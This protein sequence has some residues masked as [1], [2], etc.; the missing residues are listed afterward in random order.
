[1]KIEVAFV[2]FPL[3]RRVRGAVAER[4]KECVQ[5]F[6]HYE[7]MVRA[8][9]VLEGQE[10]TA[11]LHVMAGRIDFTV[12]ASSNEVGKAV[13]LALE[14]FETS[15]RKVSA[16]RKDKKHVFPSLENTPFGRSIRRAWSRDASSTNV[17]DKFEK[18]Y[19]NEFEDK[20][21]AG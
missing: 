13:E 1:M 8:S 7:V 17:F 6:S 15:M 16:R 9:V 5:K 19:A 12:S 14:K 20:L 4:I 10:H 11:K 2:H 21:L 18:E 3:S